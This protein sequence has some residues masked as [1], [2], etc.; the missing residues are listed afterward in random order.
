[1][2][3]NPIHYQSIFE[4]HESYE[5]K[6]QTPVTVTQHFLERIESLDSE[7]KSY[8]TVMSENAMTQAETLNKMPNDKKNGMQLFGIPIAVKDLCYTKG[9]RTMGGT[10]I[11]ENHIPDFDSTVVSKLKQAGAII[12]GKLNLTEGAMGGYNP[13]RDVPKNPW[14]FNKWSGSS[15]SGSGSSTS[16]GLCVG[17]LG[18]DTGGSIRFPSSACGLVGIKPTYGRVSRYG[19][20]DLAQSLD[21]VGPMTRTVNDA[22]LLLSAISGYDPNDQT[23]IYDKPLE[24]SDLN[25]HDLTGIV[26]GYCESFSEENVHSEIV[27]SI[28]SGLEIL[29]NLGATIKKIEFDNVD[30]YLPYWKT[31]CTAEA[32]DAHADYFPRLANDY[33]PYFREWLEFGSNVSSRE[34]IQ[35][36]KQ[37]S[38]CN[39]VFR[40]AFTGIDALI[41]PSVT[42]LAHDVNDDI[43]YGSVSISNESRGSGSYFQRFTVPFDY[44]GYP[45]LS[46]PSGYS[47]SGLPMSLQIA[48]HPLQE[49]L[50]TRIAAAYEQQV[51]SIWRN[52]IP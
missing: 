3:K 20:L 29:R 6:S 39:G 51:K 33:G 18:S 13:K 10:A 35:A 32:F 46:I 2:S 23:S 5:N 8:A 34:Y 28:R 30:E 43:S 44:N 42:R 48:G 22:A 15:S 41:S 52:P 16:A 7:L 21:H 47:K 26:L 25:N 1:M 38:L 4:I 45:T 14:D 31:L 37:R 50:I 49:N 27:D 36:S 12:L 24:F 19:V 40:K 11:L 17:S 9:V